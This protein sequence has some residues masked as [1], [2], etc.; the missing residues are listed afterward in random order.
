MQSLDPI[1]GGE[2]CLKQQ[3]AD[4]IISATND[5]LGF[6]VLRRSVGAGHPK[7]HA[8]GEEESSHG[9]VVKL[10]TRC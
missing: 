4:N 1:M 5:A 7:L 8:V 9:R 3:G 10:C 2:R 6:A